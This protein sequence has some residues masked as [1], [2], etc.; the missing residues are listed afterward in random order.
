M[1]ENGKDIDIGIT[2]AMDTGVGM[3]VGIT[4]GKEHSFHRLLSSIIL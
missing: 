2:I 4:T 3:D 1:K